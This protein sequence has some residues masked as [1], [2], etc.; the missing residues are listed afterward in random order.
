MTEQA[1]TDRIT[2][3]A[4]AAGVLA[5]GCCAGIPLAAGAIAA[6]GGLAFGAIAAA[7]VLTLGL[8]VAL[9][10]RRRHGCPPAAPNEPV[11]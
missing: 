6:V 4:A 8:G 11:R 1:K 10:R 5:I 7:V 9:L 2:I 3:G